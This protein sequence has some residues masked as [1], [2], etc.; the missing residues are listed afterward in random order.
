VDSV[1]SVNFIF[2][3]FIET[4]ENPERDQ[5]RKAETENST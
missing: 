5:E 4:P 1:F 2:A 3:S